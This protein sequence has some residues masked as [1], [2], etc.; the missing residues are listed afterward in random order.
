[1]AAAPFDDDE[2][3]RGA[4]APEQGRDRQRDLAQL[5]LPQHTDIA[6]EGADQA[7]RVLLLR[8]VA[9]VGVRNHQVAQRR[10]QIHEGDDQDRGL[11][12]G[13]DQAADER[14]AE[15]GGRDGRRNQQAAQHGAQDDGEDRQALDPAIALDQHGRG[16]HFGHDAVLGRGIGRRADAHDAVGDTDEIGLVV[17]RNADIGVGEHQ[18]AAAHLQRIGGEHHAALGEGIRQR[19]DEGGQ[20]HIRQRERPFH[21]G[22][23]PVG[24]VQLLYQG[25]GCDEQRIVRQ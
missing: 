15:Q 7:D 23:Q 20:H 10:Q 18:Q 24:P 9:H 4:G 12:R 17:G 1:M 22:G 11:G 2:L 6:P 14:V 8:R 25:D 13:V 5:V 16:Q 21:H 19:P 3:Q